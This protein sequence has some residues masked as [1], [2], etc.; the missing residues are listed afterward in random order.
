MICTPLDGGKT[1]GGIKKI[2]FSLSRSPLKM[3]RDCLVAV[4]TPTA[5]YT[6]VGSVHQG[7]LV[8]CSQCFV[9]FLC[10]SPAAN[11]HQ[12]DF[13]KPQLKFCETLI[14]CFSCKDFC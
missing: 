14:M 8:V 1:R 11:Q 9:F 4:V 10:V 2:K 3:D 13:S 12:G 7:L 6:R 5:G